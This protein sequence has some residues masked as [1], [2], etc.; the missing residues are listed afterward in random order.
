M[1]WLQHDITVFV[2]E[3][4]HGHTATSVGNHIVIFG[5]WEGNKPTNDVLILKSIELENNDDRQQE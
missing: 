2:P 3:L 4:R 5:G 1:T